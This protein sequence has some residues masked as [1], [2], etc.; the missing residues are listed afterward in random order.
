MG[1]VNGVSRNS[2]HSHSGSLGGHECLDAR[3]QVTSKKA[4]L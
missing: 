4:K 3:K 1:V 2:R